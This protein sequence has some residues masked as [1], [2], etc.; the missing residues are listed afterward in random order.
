[1]MSNTNRVEALRDLVELRV[2]VSAALARLSEFGWSSDL[3]LV[4]LATH[5]L[6]GA[7]DY[8]VAGSLDEA[9]LCA[10]AEAIQGR[11]DVELD[12]AA[13]DILA[14]ALF[15]LSTPELFGPVVEV[16]ESVRQRL[17]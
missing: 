10:W 6:A 13:R 5:D 11:E 12:P 7:L 1:M 17:Q 4:T 8:F 15:E 14:E 2:P 16:V 3:E 9:S